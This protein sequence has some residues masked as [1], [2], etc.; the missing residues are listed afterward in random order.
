MPSTRWFG[1]VEVTTLSDGYFDLPRAAFFNLDGSQ[2][3]GLT[4]PVRAGA[5][6]WLLRTGGRT[7]L[8][9]TGSGDTLKAK[10][11]ATGAL[12]DSMDSAAI[13]PSAVT[14][15]IITHMHADHIGG[16]MHDGRRRFQN[17][18]LHLLAREWTY[19]T[20]P[21]RPSN[22][23]EAQRPLAGLIAT[24]AADLTYER[25]LYDG[26]VDL[27]N[28]INLVPAPGHTPG[29]ALVQIASGD[30]Q[31][32]LLGDVVLSQAVQFADPDIRYVLDADPEQAVQTRRAVFDMLASDNIPF[33][34][35][36]M[37]ASSLVQLKHLGDGYGIEQL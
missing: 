17:A 7:I 8:V 11:P 28:G 2:P 23:P 37:N 4:D 24:L 1:D 26:E 12:P 3:D 5:H 22:V 20:D 29:H 35:T 21:S 33:L 13:D 10:Y 9:D 15:I 31:A 16:L 18:A 6:V 14:D 34:A 36:H 19:W 27:G 32:M 30:A 25:T